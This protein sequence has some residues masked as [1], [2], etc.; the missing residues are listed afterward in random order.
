M[1]TS[2]N[3]VLFG[4]ITPQSYNRNDDKSYYYYNIKVVNVG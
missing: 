4:D 3:V 1:K 2:N